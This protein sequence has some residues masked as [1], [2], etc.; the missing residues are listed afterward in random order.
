V[1]GCFSEEETPLGRRSLRLQAT[2]VD[3]VVQGSASSCS[4]AAQPRKTVVSGR[5]ALLGEYT[6]TSVVCSVH[7]SPVA[8]EFE[9]ARLVLR[10]E[11]GDELSFVSDE[12]HRGR[13][14][15]VSDAQSAVP[16]LSLEIGYSVA[17]GTGSFLGAT[18]TATLRS[19]GSLANMTLQS[20]L[21][22]TISVPLR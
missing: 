2:H 10:T 16:T 17:G 13:F 4:A 15:L 20:T 18:G 19:T 7:T 5:S 3:I 6:G 12:A 22:G 14:A 9:S 11:D 21:Q 1:P 8:G